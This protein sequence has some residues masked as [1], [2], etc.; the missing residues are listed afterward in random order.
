MRMHIE[1]SYVEVHIHVP[2]LTAVPVATVRVTPTPACPT[3]VPTE[4]VEPVA[5]LCHQNGYHHQQKQ[6]KACSG[7]DG[8]QF[9]ERHLLSS[10]FNSLE[11]LDTS[12]LH[13]S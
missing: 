5:L 10:R 9:Y 12:T 1:Y 11:S 6:L 3:V 8:L 4:P 13:L 2:E 7:H